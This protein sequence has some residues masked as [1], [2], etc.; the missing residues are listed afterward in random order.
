M[1]R[2]ITTPCIGGR[3]LGC[4]K[5]KIFSA[6]PDDGERSAMDVI[7]GPISCRTALHNQTEPTPAEDSASGSL[8]SNGERRG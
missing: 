6:V 4:L 2:P 1:I 3:R 8:A 5:W 7:Y